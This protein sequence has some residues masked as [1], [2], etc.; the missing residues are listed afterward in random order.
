MPRKFRAIRY[1][2]CELTNFLQLKVAVQTTLPLQQEKTF[3]KQ[4]KAATCRLNAYGG[5]DVITALQC[6]ICGY[7]FCTHCSDGV[8]LMNG[9]PVYRLVYTL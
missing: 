2:I 6:Y 9:Q 1:I 5:V 8:P 7:T 4:Y 3:D